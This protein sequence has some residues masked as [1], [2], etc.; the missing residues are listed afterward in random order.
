MSTVGETATLLPVLPPVL[1]RSPLQRVAET[2]DQLRALEPPEA[3]KVGV[4]ARLALSAGRASR[5][6]ESSR[7]GCDGWDSTNR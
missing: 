4:A 6:R 5:D 3:M 7:S 1:N 2:L